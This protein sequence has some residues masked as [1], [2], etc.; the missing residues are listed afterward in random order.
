MHHADTMASCH[1][2]FLVYQCSTTGVIVFWIILVHG[3]YQ[4]HPGSWLGIP[5]VD[6]PGGGVILIRFFTLR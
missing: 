5:T 4:N 3:S 1:D 2:K 6:N